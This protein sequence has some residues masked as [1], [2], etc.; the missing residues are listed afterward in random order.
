MIHSPVPSENKFLN[1]LGGSTFIG[2]DD[3][4][5]PANNGPGNHRSR[6]SI[7]NDASLYDSRT[8]FLDGL[9]NTRVLSWYF[10]IS[11]VNISHQQK[12]IKL[13]PELS[14]AGLSSIAF[15][16]DIPST[17]HKQVG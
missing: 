5:I 17:C 13:Y 1:I 16:R 6:G 11:F 4:L 14:K 15:L 2:N 7:G 3:G 12:A 9:E 8:M 10:I